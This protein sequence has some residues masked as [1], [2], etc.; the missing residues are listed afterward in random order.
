MTATPE[1]LDAGVSI[2]ADHR[3]GDPLYATTEAMY[4][5]MRALEPAPVVLPWNQPAPTTKH[6][7]SSSLSA[8]LWNS[9]SDRAGNINFMA[10]YSVFRPL[11]SDPWYSVNGGAMTVPFRA[12]WSV[13]SHADKQMIVYL[14]TSNEVVEMWNAS[15]NHTAKTITASRASRVAVD[16]MQHP[17]SRGIGIPYHHLLITDEE[18]RAG[19]IKHALSLR[20]G[21]P[22][23]TQAWYPA[24]K[25]EG[26]TGCDPNGIPEGARFVCAFT[27]ARIDA[28]AATKGTLA[29]FARALAA[30]LQ[31]YGF[32]ITDNGYFYAG[33]DVQ[34]PKSWSDANPLK[35]SMVASF[36]AMQ[37]I[38]DGLIQ[39]TDFSLCVETGPRLT[40]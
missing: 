6:A 8:Y 7:L 12:G 4:D 15:V 24:S 32:F 3:L 2:L 16:L 18:I 39:Q 9:G 14:P 35:T 30:A 31:T 13:T 27:Q 1:M 23:C 34:D 38:L 37:N 28:W 26:T 5:A 11:L 20:I 36:T 25:V 19:E 17:P 33:F 40:A 22:H 10:T 29:P 21:R